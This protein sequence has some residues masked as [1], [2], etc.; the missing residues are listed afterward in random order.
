MGRLIKGLVAVGLMFSLTACLDPKAGEQCNN[1]G[2]VRVVA[3]EVFECR[4]VIGET[5]K[6]GFG[7]EFPVARWYRLEAK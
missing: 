6:N 1:K 2:E 7:Q 5:R 3:K 4:V